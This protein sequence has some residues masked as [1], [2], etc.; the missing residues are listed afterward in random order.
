MFG[1]KDASGESARRLLL[2]CQCIKTLDTRACSDALY[3]DSFN[4]SP[5]RREVF[6]LK[7][8]KFEDFFAWHLIFFYRHKLCKIIFMSLK[9]LFS[10]ICGFRIPGSGS[11][12]SSSSGFRILVPNSGF[13][14]LGFRVAPHIACQVIEWISRLCSS[15]IFRAPVGHLT[16]TSR[17]PS[18]SG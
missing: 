18:L 12:S 3:F 11:G 2:K 13:R 16:M 6:V 1:P 4:P 14:F 9:N 15:K 10:L 7:Q 5:H 8:V 17:S